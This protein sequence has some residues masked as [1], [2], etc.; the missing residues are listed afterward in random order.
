MKITESSKK[1]LFSNIEMKERSVS[2]KTTKSY[3]DELRVLKNT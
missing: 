3:I 2:V 1:A